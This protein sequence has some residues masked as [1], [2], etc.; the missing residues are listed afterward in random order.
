LSIIEDAGHTGSEAMRD[1]IIG[2]LD[3]FARTSG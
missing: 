1:R 2:A 3:G